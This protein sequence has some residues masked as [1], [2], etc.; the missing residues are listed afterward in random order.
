MTLQPTRIIW[1]DHTDVET[2]NGQWNTPESILELTGPAVV[3][4]VGYIVREE[5]E[6]IAVASSSVGDN[7]GH[8][9][10]I[11]KSCVVSRSPLAV[12]RG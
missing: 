10:I 2:D 7:W 11:I 4:T 8:I 6:W 12:K 9:T 3:E 5:K 1:Q